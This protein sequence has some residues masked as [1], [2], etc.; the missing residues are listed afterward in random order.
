MKLNRTQIRRI[1]LEELTSSSPPIAIKGLK[2][3][4]EFPDAVL[5]APIDAKNLIS[6]LK[7]SSKYK[8]SLQYVWKDSKVGIADA[9]L[10]NIGELTN[11]NGDPFTY[12]K[13][14]SKF[15]VISGPMPK[16]IGKIFSLS[17]EP[18]V[19]TLDLMQ[20]PA[21][22][23]SKDILGM[24]LHEYTNLLSPEKKNI[25]NQWGIFS[26]N[27]NMT[28]SEWL[29]NDKK[30]IK[31]HMLDFQNIASDVKDKKSQS[32]AFRAP[33][34]LIDAYIAGPDDEN[35]LEEVYENAIDVFVTEDLKSA[36]KI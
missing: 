16:T 25:F 13:V 30:I 22:A 21:Q 18:S 27:L 11:G 5:V 12:N 2:P 6:K 17:P 24:K 33:I 1:I 29:S 20:T 10:Y 14:G 35:A 15:R 36:L 19:K 4:N 8:T 31:K 23:E 28:V 3:T 32:G 34:N 26:T 7:V 9:N